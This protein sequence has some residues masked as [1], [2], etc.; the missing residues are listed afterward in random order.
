MPGALVRPP[1]DPELWFLDTSCAH[2]GRPRAEK[3]PLRG[4][5]TA[6]RLL[7]C[8]WGSHLAVPTGE[9]GG[10]KKQGSKW[11]LAFCQF[12]SVCWSGW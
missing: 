2:W 1:L 8:T 5:C 12:L 11:K 4:V 7:P 10:L 6:C 9:V 3:A